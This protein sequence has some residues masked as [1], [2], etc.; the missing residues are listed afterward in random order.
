MAS[1]P[2]LAQSDGVLLGLAVRHPAT[3]GD[4]GQLAEL[5]VPLLV[6]GLRPELGEV[7][8]QVL[9][10]ADG[11]ERPLRVA[12]RHLLVVALGG[13]IG[14]GVSAALR[15]FGFL[16]LVE[17]LGLVLLGV[18]DLFGFGLFRRR[19]AKRGRLVVRRGRLVEDGRRVDDGDRS[20]DKIAARHL[21]DAIGRLG[22]RR[23]LERGAALLP[24]PQPLGVLGADT[25]R[26]LGIVLHKVAELVV[27]VGHPDVT[28]LRREPMVQLVLKRGE[29]RLDGMLDQSRTGLG[30]LDAGEPRV[31]R[32]GRD[33]N[34]PG[35][36]AERGADVL[37]RDPPQVRK[38]E[39]G[40]REPERLDVAHGPEERGRPALPAIH[41]AGA[42][43]VL[44]RRRILGRRL[45][46]HQHRERRRPVIGHDL[47]DVLRRLVVR[48]QGA[49][50][51]RPTGIAEDIGLEGTA[52]IKVSEV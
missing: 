35:V 14:H 15:L 38:L 46:A 41:H 50:S 23:E 25:G 45:V 7:L 49:D 5:L 10:L 3:L 47:P 36:D 48:E 21:Q 16:F 12:K 40:E 2:R 18:L 43:A 1:D 31:A 13:E 8:L 29:H 9:G 30:V 37:T 42:V 20:R 39:V 22:E 17:L 27:V 19:C 33:A 51:G 34:H 26:G 24:R 11:E 6:P 28:E 32:G 4:G 52:H 44:H